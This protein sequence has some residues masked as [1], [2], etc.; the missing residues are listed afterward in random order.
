MKVRCGSLEI[1]DIPMYSILELKQTRMLSP[2]FELHEIK[3]ALDR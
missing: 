2:N 1:L 3:Q